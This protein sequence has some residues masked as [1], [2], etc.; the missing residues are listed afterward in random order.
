MGLSLPNVPP[1]M[2][3]YN[4]MYQQ[5]PM[6]YPGYMHTQQAQLIP[7]Q[8]IP[9]QYPPNDLYFMPGY[10]DQKSTIV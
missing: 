3:G 6:H 7:T 9:S 2:S 5:P 1:Q 4:P 10:Y 8:M